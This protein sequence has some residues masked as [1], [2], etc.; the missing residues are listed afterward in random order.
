MPN[1]ARAGGV[2]SSLLAVTMLLG[3][4]VAPSPA[5]P[6]TGCVT[7]SPRSCLLPYPSD[8][9]LVADAST[10]T[11][12][13]VSMPDDVFP[14]SVTGQFRPG[15]DQRTAYDGADGFSPMTPIVFQ[16]DRPVAGSELPTDGGT[17]AVVTDDTTGARQEIRAERSA[18]AARFGQADT[19]VMLWPAL[20][21]PAGHRITAHLR[22]AGRVEVST[23]FVVRSRA[24]ALGNLDS[25]VA[26][27]RADDH[28]VRNIATGPSLLG[29]SQLVSGE[30]ATTD[31]RSDDGTIGSGTDVP[32][33]RTW[34]RFVMTMPEKPMSAAGAPVAIYGHG[35]T[36]FKET[37]AFDAGPNA[38][39]GVATIGID[40]PNHGE[41]MND[42][43]SVL[44][45]TITP[46]LGRLVAMP[47]QGSLDQLSLLLAVRDHLGAAVPGLDTSRILYEGTS[48]G[49]FLGMEFLS[50]AP[51][52]EAA[53]LQVPGSGIVDT[54]YHS[55]IW[56]LFS[57]ILP[58][59]VSAGESGALLGAAMMMLDRTENALVIDR[60]R[61]LGTPVRIVYGASDG[62]V[63]NTSTD[64][65]LR[66][67]ASP[68]V[69]PIKVVAPTAAPDG[70]AV[71]GV[72][73]DPFAPDRVATQI[74]TWG[75]QQTWLGPLLTHL[76]FLDQSPME[77]LGAWLD[78]R[79]V[80]RRDPGGPQQCERVAAG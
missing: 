12:V 60:V 8:R 63:P 2:A 3:S 27:V 21:W 50:F 68:V 57:G 77:D 69:G 26:A 9:Y 61:A 54:L 48:M 34:V 16:F 72:D 43:G 28:P 22:V 76:S 36:A 23:S 37:L 79:V 80:C 62:I 55:A 25:L 42:G 40:I 44:D 7:S 49:G 58:A 67:L 33:R 73:R 20:M 46:K 51:E 53:F 11:G 19:V 59:G 5:T 39:R 38:A 1:R 47:L 65:M 24:N 71:E 17:V 29:G 31:F 10:A 35:I 32:H 13:R 45:L 18:D 14:A 74:D 41:R 30:V 52:V 15:G 4:C 56:P 66:L 70:V 75:E 64:R 6:T 78:R